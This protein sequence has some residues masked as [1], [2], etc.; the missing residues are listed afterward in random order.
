MLGRILKGYRIVEKIRDGSVGT[1]YKV[2]GQDR[3]IYA[4]KMLSLKN[5]K[6][7]TKRYQFSRE[8]KVAQ[9]LDHP[10]IIKVFRYYKVSPQP[11]F[12]MEYFE[13]EN[14]RYSMW[15]LPERVYRK[16]FLI[17]AQVAQALEFVHQNNIVHCDI[18]PENVLIN[19]RAQIRLIDFSIAQTKRTW[20]EKV[21]GSFIHG[22]STGTP[23]YI[24]PEQIKG[25]RV[26]YRADI[27]SFGV[28]MYELLTKRPPFIGTSEKSILNKHLTQPPPPL[29]Q[30][31]KTISS[32]IEEFVL[33]LLEKEPDKRPSSMSDVI[34]FL[35][36]WVDKKTTII[37]KQVA[38]PRKWSI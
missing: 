23:L 15:H 18:K 33:M 16:E 11:F 21:I 30:F 5:A 8:A 29:K 14:L 36:A 27:Y 6:L 26:D 32:E 35:S 17:L 37:R 9:K 19:K 4:L 22:R 31:V 20:I 25:T 10:Y 34:N 24:S 13:S 3:K 12:V 38:E 2:M 7:S 28:L 1:V